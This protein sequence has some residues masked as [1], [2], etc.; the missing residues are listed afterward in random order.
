EKQFPYLMSPETI[1]DAVN[2]NLEFATFAREEITRLLWRTADFATATS[3]VALKFSEDLRSR[4]LASDSD[5]KALAQ[6]MNDLLRDVPKD[7]VT[8]GQKVLAL[9]LDGSQ[10]LMDLNVAAAR[11]LLGLGETLVSRAEQAAKQ[12]AEATSAY[13]AKVQAIYRPAS[14]N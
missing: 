9:T 3:E 12:N 6:G 10:K 2:K 1:A 7:P 13:L 4:L 11:G 5:V 8:L 14:Q